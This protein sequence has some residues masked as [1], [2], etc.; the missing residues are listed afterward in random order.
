MTDQPSRST[1]P[2]ALA[3]LVAIALYLFFTVE[4]DL[5]PKD[6]RP[7]GDVAALEALA[8]RDDV[9]VLFILVDT[10]RAS[11]MSAYGYERETTPFL[12]SLVSTGVRFDYHI[13]QSSWTKSSMASLWTGLTPIRSG[14]TKF[15]HTLSEGLRMP[16]EILRDA[17]FRTVGLFR[18]GW[19]SGY[20]G[21]DQGFDRYHRPM[22][23]TV[24]ESIQRM[25]PNAAAHGTDES[26]VTE[27]I[28][29]L[30]I[31]GDVEHGPWFLY[32]HLMD[33][34]EY[35]YDE[36]SARFGS[37]VADLY[38][39]SVLRTD[40]ILSTLYADLAARGLL[41]NTI[42]V[43]ASDHG[44]AFGERGYEG[45]ARE[46]FPETTDTPLLISFPFRIEGGAVVDS[47]TSN[48]DLWPT[49]LDLLGLEGLPET[50][51]ASRVPEIA[52]AISGEAETRPS[53]E[54]EPDVVVAFLD[55]N[56]GKPN[57]SRLPAI[58]VTDGPFRYVRGSEN[59]G[60]RFEVLLSR[61][62]GED[63]SVIDEHPEVAERL[64]AAAD[65]ELDRDAV[66]ESGIIELDEMQLDQLRA[67]GYEL[68]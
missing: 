54:S 58:S 41:D 29:F 10:L 53:A 51:G 66:F 64:R 55:E 25:R 9:N 4:V 61:D 63:R 37:T 2:F 27:A 43:L 19:V 40:W 46:V 50:D 18:N 17:G 6:E 47:R 3:A 48:L 23:R 32:L 59:S 44:E 22:G 35:T 24:D 8:E 65:A 39:N 30:R 5:G 20:F 14:I 1:W 16:A 45:H 11:R 13:A 56:W 60:R 52:Q 34:H 26:L 7:P 49:L 21:F 68:P 36:E 15:D 31:Y 33:L 57:T 38:D 28:E 67:L 62:G 42:V 12:E